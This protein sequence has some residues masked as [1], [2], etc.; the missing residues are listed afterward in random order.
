[1]PLRIPPLTL[2]SWRPSKSPSKLWVPPPFFFPRL[3]PILGPRAVRRP[4]QDAAAA[5]LLA[6]Q[7]S[8]HTGAAPRACAEAMAAA[9]PA[10]PPPPRGGRYPPRRTWLQTCPRRPGSSFPRGRPVRSS[11]RRPW[12]RR[13]SP[14]VATSLRRA[15]WQR[16][17][18]SHSCPLPRAPWMVVRRAR[19][20]MGWMWR[21]PASAASGDH[22]G[23]AAH[24]TSTAAECCARGGPCTRV[25][26]VMEAAELH[27]VEVGP[28]SPTPSRSSTRNSRSSTSASASLTSSDTASTAR[29]SPRLPPPPPPSGA[30]PS[31]MSASAVTALAGTT[32]QARSS[33]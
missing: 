8:Q 28:P 5:P 18:T 12:G 14:E 2:H 10:P 31:T 3:L 13:G 26:E 25:L 7:A 24:S 4:S 23:G 17:A 29:S 22:C 27:L 32:H 9:A 33:N 11:C 15:R 30:E 19:L 6:P 20:S 1:M 16:T 21:R